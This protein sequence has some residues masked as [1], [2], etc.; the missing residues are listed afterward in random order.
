MQ[1]YIFQSFGHSMLNSNL[2]TVISQQCVNEI[3]KRA[4]KQI[5]IK[6]KRKNDQMKNPIKPTE[7]PPILD[8]INEKES[9]SVVSEDEKSPSV[10]TKIIAKNESLE[11][12]KPYVINDGNKQTPERTYRNTLKMLGEIKNGLK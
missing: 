2:S 7:T 6:E 12:S 11:R 4:E 5:M 8:P 1:K 9:S 10:G 3:V